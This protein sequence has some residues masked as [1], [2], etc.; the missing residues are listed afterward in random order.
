[1]RTTT[2]SARLGKDEAEQ[3]AALARAA[4]LD[5]ASFIKQMLKRGIAEYR[6]EQACTAYR[7]GDVT[8]SRAAE[9]AGLGLYELLRRLPAESLTLNYDVAALQ[10]DIR[11]VDSL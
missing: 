1:M 10:A 5:R 6:F 7:H 11:K 9:M 3:L 2:V 8:L 4:D